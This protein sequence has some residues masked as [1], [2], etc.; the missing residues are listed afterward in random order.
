MAT[1][2]GREPLPMLLMLRETLRFYPPVPVCPL[3]KAKTSVLG[4]EDLGRDLGM[5]SL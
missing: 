1:D 2:L 4:A 3:P 5:K